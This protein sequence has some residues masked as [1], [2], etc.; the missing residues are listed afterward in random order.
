MDIGC[1]I[2]VLKDNLTH[3]V[4]YTGVELSEFAK[5]V[6]ESKGLKVYNETIQNFSKESK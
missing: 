5:S 6:A 2:G 4:D 1:G 3:I